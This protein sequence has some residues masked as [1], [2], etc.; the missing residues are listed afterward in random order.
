MI[1]R[2]TH[3]AITRRRHRGMVVARNVDDCIKQVVQELGD[4]IGLVVIRQP[5]LHQIRRSGKAATDST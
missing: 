4:Y 1:F 5:T 2:V 3:T